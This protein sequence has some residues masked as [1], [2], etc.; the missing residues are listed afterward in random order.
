MITFKFQNA[1]V[2]APDQW[3]EVT[4]EHFIRPEFLTRDPVGLLAVLTGIEKGVLMNATEDISQELGRMVSFIAKE[5]T[6]YKGKLPDRFKIMDKLVKIPKDIE[7][8][9]LGQKI[10]FSAALGKYKFAYEAIP[11]IIA[12]Y[13]IPQMTSDGSFDDNMIDE[14]KDAVKKMPI[15]YVYPVADFFLDSLKLSRRNGTP[16]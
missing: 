11:E 5:P 15:T 7:L 16:S 13:L 3:S 9:K 4:V 6:G 10:L 1:T 2:E 8:E 12:I 14:V